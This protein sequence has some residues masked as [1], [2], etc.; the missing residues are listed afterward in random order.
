MFKKIL[1]SKNNSV[2]L[3]TENHATNYGDIILKFKPMLEL[4]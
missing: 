3:Q 4:F 1:S 2:I